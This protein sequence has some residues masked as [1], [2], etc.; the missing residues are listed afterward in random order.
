MLPAAP[1]AGVY[2]IG[3]R[4][5]YVGIDGEPSDQPSVEY[6]DSKTRRLGTLT[7][8]SGDR[9]QTDGSPVIRFSLGQPRTAVSERRFAIRDA[10]GP[11]GFSLWSAG[12]VSAKA[13]IVLIQGADD[14]TRDMGFLIPYFVGHG[15]NVV[16]YDQRGTG[17]SAGNWHYTSPDEKAQD[18]LAMIATLKD[19][20]VVDSKRIGLWAASNGGWVA[21]IVALQYPVAFMI[22]KSA[23]SESIASNILY[24]VQQS[25]REPGTFSPAQIAAALTFEGVML[26]AVRQDA[27]WPVAA[28]A[29][30]SARREPWFP[31]MRIPPGL[32]I[33][34][35]APMLAA[36]QASLVYDPSATLAQ[37]RVPT[38][39]LF[40]ARDKNVDEAD[41]QAGFRKAFKRAGMNDFTV[42]VFPDTGHTLLESRT[43]YIDKP[44][45][46]QRYTGYPEVMA[47]WLE[48]RGFSS[49]SLQN[50]TPE[51]RRDPTA[52]STADRHMTHEYA[53]SLGCY[54]GTPVATGP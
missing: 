4:A 24:E 20:P 13:T 34:P 45:L 39:A 10:G 53:Y 11:F 14:S 42:H 15:L 33:P 31:Y 3:N 17:S 2:E 48:A 52:G 18:V 38:L 5:V 54:A 51:T 1:P 32:P 47:T 46:P 7:H 49:G 16:T 22:L 8:V 6:Y 41:S 25:L 36:L 28:A 44:D 12:G 30:S 19:D 29:L 26:Q 35:P 21:P 40:G 23:P 27:G 50:S 43:G 9:Y 37:V